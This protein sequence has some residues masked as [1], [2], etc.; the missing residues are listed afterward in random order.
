MTALAIPV[1]LYGC[2]WV[3]AVT[4]SPLKENGKQITGATEQVV[5]LES[6]FCERP[7]G[8]ASIPGAAIP[9]LGTA[10]L[11]LLG[12]E[13]ANKVE[14]PKE[15]SKRAYSRTLLMDRSELGSLLRDRCLILTRYDKKSGEQT[16]FL[17]LQPTIRGNSGSALT[18][19]LSEWSLTNTVSDTQKDEG[20]RPVI[21]LVVS[22]GVKGINDKGTLTT[23]SD[24]TL[25]AK[26]VPIP[27][28][29]QCP[30][31]DS[32]CARTDLMAMPSTGVDYVSVSVGVVERGTFSDLDLAKTQVES[33][34]TALGG[35][36]GEGLKADIKRHNEK[37]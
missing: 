32:K 25:T 28:E 15:S 8:I 34:A 26:R 11:E 24:G 16:A 35:A 33:L 31:G 36:L 5:E 27:N 13:L 3:P 10:A 1:V 12:Q 30:V 9:A 37:K 18:F 29:G 21:D 22:V 7:Q 6:N 4:Y 17:M 14:K 2:S 20:K 19:E 23:L